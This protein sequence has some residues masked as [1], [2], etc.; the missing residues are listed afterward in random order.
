MLLIDISVAA[1]AVN[2]GGFRNEYGSNR[3]WSGKNTL[4]ARKVSG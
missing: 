3:K 4:C 1:I 2:N